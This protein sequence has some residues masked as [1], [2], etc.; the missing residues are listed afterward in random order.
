MI[1]NLL[2][3]KCRLMDCKNAFWVSCTD[4]EVISQIIP[5][6]D[7]NIER[8][9]ETIKHNRGANNLEENVGELKYNNF[10]LISAD[11]TNIISYGWY[12][13]YSGMW[14]AYNPFRIIDKKI[15]LNLNDLK[16]LEERLEA[17]GKFNIEQD[18]TLENQ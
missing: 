15:I 10:F 2:W 3:P 7:G 14:N 1:V 16:I 9:I 13:P 6:L 12:M 4:E 11:S 18:E 17:E 5:M 8:Q